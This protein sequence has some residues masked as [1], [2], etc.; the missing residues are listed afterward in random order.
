MFAAKIEEVKNGIDYYLTSNKF[1]MQLGHELKKRFAVV[2]KVSRKLY[3]RDKTTGKKI[4]RIN[5]LI[6]VLDYEKGDRVN[7]NGEI[8]IVKKISKKITIVNVRS[9]KR[10]IVDPLDIKI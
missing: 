10:E 9:G 8:Y 6:R 2:H 5:V 1:L 3:S 4:W 7:Y